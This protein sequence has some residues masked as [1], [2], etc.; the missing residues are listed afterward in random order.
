MPITER[1]FVSRND[2]NNNNSSLWLKYNKICIFV[3]YIDREH[4]LIL[5]NTIDKLM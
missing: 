2:R 5:L 3:L 1:N 4:C